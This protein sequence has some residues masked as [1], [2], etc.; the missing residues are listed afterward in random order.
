MIQAITYRASGGNAARLYQ[1]EQLQ[2]HSHVV[3]DA[4]MT[5]ATTSLSSSRLSSRNSEISSE[6]MLSADR[7]AAMTHLTSGID[8]SVSA[9]IGEAKV[10]PCRVSRKAVVVQP[11]SGEFSNRA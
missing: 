1:E 3:H 9:P 5:L 11:K 7:S 4:D 2:Q 8:N 10:G 6:S